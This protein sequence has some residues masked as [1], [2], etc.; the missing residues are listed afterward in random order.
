MSFSGDDMARI[1]ES[2]KTECEFLESILPVK[3]FAHLTTL[4]KISS[5]HLKSILRAWILGIQKHHGVTMGWVRSIESLPQKHIHA[6]LIAPV[7]IDCD[8]A[9]ALWQ[10]LASPGY[11]EAA[12]VEP[13]L[14]GRCGLGYVL[15]QLC[16]PSGDIEYSDNITAFSSRP[17]KSRFPTTPRQRRNQRRIQRQIAKADTSQAKGHGNEDDSHT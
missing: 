14:V 9:A 15:K 8:Y 4:H 11:S 12:K 10:A 5:D 1:P 13:Y 3:S 16:S 6:A 7:P 17:L 2:A